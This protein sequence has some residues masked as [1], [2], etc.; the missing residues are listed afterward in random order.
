MQS[1]PLAD[2]RWKHRLLVVDAP[3]TASGRQALDAFRK[4]V[5]AQM[6][7]VLDRDLLI[8][9]VGDLPR[10][11]E[12]RRPWVDLPVDARLAVRR[13]LALKGGGPPQLVLVGKDGG[14]KARQSG[15]FDLARMLTEIDAM[16]MRRAERKQ[17]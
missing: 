2:W 3:D 1:D 4:A 12:T 7:D 6:E 11:G 14:A 17:Q 8:V 15:V 9:P 16:P 5:D 13:Q 10:A